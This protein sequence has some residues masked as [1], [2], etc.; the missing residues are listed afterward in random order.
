M[1]LR[2]FRNRAAFVLGWSMQSSCLS[3]RLFELSAP[4]LTRHLLTSLPAAATCRWG[5]K[6]RPTEPNWMTNLLTG[7]SF[8][9]VLACRFVAWSIF[10]LIDL[11][12][13]PSVEK[14]H[15][16]LTWTLFVELYSYILSCPITNFIRFRS[17]YFPCGLS[18]DA[19][20]NILSE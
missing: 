14:W 11:H 2:F 13:T 16:S 20:K 4:N 9:A 15:S 8:F 18:P 5:E 6:F 7:P 17:W 10:S 1:L 19:G 3:F 12:V